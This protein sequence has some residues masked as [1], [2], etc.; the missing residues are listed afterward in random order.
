MR[1]LILAAYV[2]LS[3]FQAVVICSG[4]DAWIGIP[5]V[6]AV[7]VATLLGLVP[8]AGTIVAILAAGSAWSWPWFGS[9]ALFCSLLALW[10]HVILHHAMPA[11]STP[12]GE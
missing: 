9:T 10:V 12:E 3:T 6:A 2:A 7:P 5:D 4:L 8:G 1:F 11:L